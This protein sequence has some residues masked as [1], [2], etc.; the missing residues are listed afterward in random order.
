MNSMASAG[1]MANSMFVVTPHNGYPVVPG[2]MSQIPRYPSNQPQV[3]LIPGN[4]P[5]QTPY[6]S[7]QPARPV[8][9]E[10][11]VLGALQILIGLIHIGFGSILATVL[12]GYY[13]AISFYAG[14]PFWGSI[15]FNLSGSLS[16]S[17]ETQPESSCPLSGSMGMNIVSAISSAVGIMLFITGIS[18][19]AITFIYSNSLPYSWG[20]PGMAISCVLLVFCLLEF[21]IACTASHFS[22]QL[23]C[24]QCNNVSMVFP[25]VYTANKVVVPEP[26]NPPPEYSTQVPGSK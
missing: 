3:H 8:L 16:V 25:N 2:V 7:E 5:G 13:I 12:S 19:A 11:K 10:G 17:A 20:C 22:C 26:E 4:P 15:C 23:T 1:P 18:I 9:K 6:V 24:Y 21:C 14:F